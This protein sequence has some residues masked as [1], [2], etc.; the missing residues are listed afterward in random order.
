VQYQSNPKLLQEELEMPLRHVVGLVAIALLVSCASQRPMPSVDYMPSAVRGATSSLE[1]ALEGGREALWQATPIEQLDARGHNI[2][3]LRGGDI[4]CWRDN[5]L[6]TFELTAEGPFVRIAVAGSYSVCGTRPDGEV[7]CGDYVSPIRDPRANLVAAKGLLCT[8][9]GTSI[10]CDLRGDSGRQLEFEVSDDAGDV[11]SLAAH[12]ENLATSVLAVTSTGALYRWSNLR[13]EVRGPKRVDTPPLERVRQV[14]YGW[15]GVT[16]GG[17]VVYRGTTFGQRHSTGELCGVDRAQDVRIGMHRLCARTPEGVVCWKPQNL[18]ER[19]LRN[20][21]L[22]EPC[23]GP[24]GTMAR[25]DVVHIADSPLARF[26]VATTAND[27]E[28]TTS[29]PT[30]SQARPV[31][32]RN[33]AQIA[34]GAHFN[35][36]LLEDGRVE[37]V[38]PSTSLEGVE[39]DELRGS[40]AIYAGGHVVCGVVEKELRCLFSTTGED[41]K[42]TWQP[43]RP[44]KL[45]DEPSSVLVRDHRVSWEAN[46][47]VYP[48][49]IVLPY[50]DDAAMGVLEAWTER[51]PPKFRPEK[52]QKVSKPERPLRSASRSYFLTED[53]QL[54]RIKSR[55]LDLAGVAFGIVTGG[56]W[57]PMLEWDQPEDRVDIRKIPQAQEL[58]AGARHVCHRNDDGTVE[59]FG[60][61]DRGPVS[62]TPYEARVGAEEP[63]AHEFSSPAVQLS[64]GH[65]HTCA[66]LESGDVRCWGGWGAGLVRPPD[67]YPGLRTVGW[68]SPHGEAQR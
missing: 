2:C 67:E 33:A 13:D 54:F 46:G 58:A 16:K 9:S 29:K 1:R 27:V 44:V 60:A 37:C 49:Q 52:P 17:R 12:D 47:R 57:I 25:E 8:A 43:I 32:H 68:S 38:G 28:C 55:G 23:V 35:C 18:N 15:A 61:D 39:L 30:W 26:C 10:H 59:C 19:E 42:L 36:A 66:R 64:A 11:V 56:V 62:G 65:F 5:F 14:R 53:G 4:Y 24:R 41:S 22:H 63:Y 3:A 51:A 34:S 50:R 31:V 7:V 20:G 48:Y 40:S 21:P 45:H 6:E